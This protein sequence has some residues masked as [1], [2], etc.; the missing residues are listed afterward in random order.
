MKTLFI[1]LAVL[2]ASA[3]FASG[4]LA[5]HQ[6]TGRV[7]SS[8]P[9]V[10]QVAVPRQVCTVDPASVQPQ[11]RSGAGALLGA[12]A[13]GAMGNAVGDGSGRA[14]ATILGLIGGA[15]LGERVE[16]ASP[17]PQRPMQQCSTQYFYENRATAY[18]VVYEYAGKQYSVQLPYD[19]GPTIKLQIL[20]AGMSNSGL[21][22]A[23]APPATELAVAPVQTQVAQPIPTIQR[24]YLAE[25]AYVVR[26]Y[27][28]PI[29][30]SFGFGSHRGHRHHF[31]WY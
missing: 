8:T 30:L 22:P 13:G 25:P 4:A 31:R 9:I 3:P 11:Q 7:L 5:Q 16:N 18:N 1:N 20:P 2:I 6:E 17:Q 19:P 21:E 23:L 24:I 12:I 10:Q 26:H 15:I 14:A 28:P 27:H 29:S